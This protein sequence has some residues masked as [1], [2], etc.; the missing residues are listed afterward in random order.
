MERE[1]QKDRNREEKWKPYFLCFIE[2][3]RARI[4]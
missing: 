3:T 4:T 1:R 2:G